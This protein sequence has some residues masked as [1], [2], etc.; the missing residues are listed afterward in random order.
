MLSCQGIRDGILSVAHCFIYLPDLN[1][2]LLLKGILSLTFSIRET[3]EV[4]VI[5]PNGKRGL[6]FLVFTQI[7]HNF[8]PNLRASRLYLVLI[9]LTLTSTKYK[10]Y[11]MRFLIL[12]NYFLYCKNYVQLGHLPLYYQKTQIVLLQ[13]SSRNLYCN[14]IPYRSEFF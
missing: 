10:N 4:I 11:E 3:I 12:K 13:L 5:I 7:Y 9:F 6:D 8:I 2:I 14:S 1:T